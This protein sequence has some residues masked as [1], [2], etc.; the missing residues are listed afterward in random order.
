M[1]EIRHIDPAWLPD[2]SQ[3]SMDFLESSFFKGK[4]PKPRLPAPDEFRA[5][6]PT[7]R[8]HPKP[9]PVKFGDLDLVVKFGRYVSVSGALCLWAIK[10]LFGDE[11]PVPEVYAWRVDGPDV[12]IYMQLICGEPLIDRWDCLGDEDKTAVCA[13]LHEILVS[14][15]R[16]EQVP[17]DTFIGKLQNR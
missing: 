7:Y 5:L 13:Q 12:F 9:V 1:P 15:R 6:S 2:A 10:K 16:V 3:A 17:G 14:L 8:T 11:I 4:D